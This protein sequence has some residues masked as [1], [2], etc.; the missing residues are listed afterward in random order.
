MRL[1][2]P[3]QFLIYLVASWLARQQ[4]EA[5][6]TCGRRTR[7]LRSRLRAKRLCL[8]D[9]ERGFLAEKGRPLG[10]RRL[11][12]VASPYGTKARSLRKTALEPPFAAIW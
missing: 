12:E 1:L 4:G 2:A 7:L 8:T 9:A 6:D 10:R 11:A 3:L 5:I